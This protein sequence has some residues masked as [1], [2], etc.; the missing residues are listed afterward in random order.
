MCLPVLSHWSCDQH[1]THPVKTRNACYK[2]PDNPSSSFFRSL[3]QGWLT[4][5]QTNTRAISRH[6]LFFC[7]NWKCTLTYRWNFTWT[8]CRG[9][10]KTYHFAHSA[11][12][13]SGQQWT[14]SLLNVLIFIC[15]LSID[16]WQS[17]FTH[18]ITFSSNLSSYINILY[19]EPLEDSWKKPYIWR[20]WLVC[21]SVWLP[22]WHSSHYR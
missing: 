2:F 20:L 10:W 17:L 3:D 7:A 14:A 6:L 5:W 22:V 16:I 11:T 21:P 13:T 9:V 8:K 12:D 15:G 1:R 4:D 19:R 18:R